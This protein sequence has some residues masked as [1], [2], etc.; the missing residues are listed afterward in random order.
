MKKEEDPL[1]STHHNQLE[2]LLIFFFSARYEES[3]LPYPD[4]AMTKFL[5][6]ILWLFDENCIEIPS[7]L[8]EKRLLILCTIRGKDI[9]NGDKRSL[10]PGIVPRYFSR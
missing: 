7:L 10:I 2:K 6:V 1:K 3:K 8:S 9:G 4:L 5:K